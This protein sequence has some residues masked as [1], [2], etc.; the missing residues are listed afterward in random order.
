MDKYA[1]NIVV[2]YTE[3]EGKE[4]ISQMLESVIFE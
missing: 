2:G 4:E 1:F 3:E